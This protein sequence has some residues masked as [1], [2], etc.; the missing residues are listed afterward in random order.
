MADWIRLAREGG[1]DGYQL[2]ESCAVVRGGKD[3]SV[4]M[5]QPAL[6]ELF[7]REFGK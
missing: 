1:Y 6:R 2:Y 7:Q 3:G 5:E 4:T